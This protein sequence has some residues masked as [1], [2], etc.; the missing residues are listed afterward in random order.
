MIQDIILE[1]VKAVDADESWVAIWLKKL[2]LRKRIT[3]L[4]E[5]KPLHV[6]TLYDLSKSRL[7]WKK[8][9]G[10]RENITEGNIVPNPTPIPLDHVA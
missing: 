10:V 7:F 8:N 9:I 5:I 1:S 3:P 6:T 2:L 4:H